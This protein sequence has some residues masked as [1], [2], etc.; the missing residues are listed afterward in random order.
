MQEW[1]LESEVNGLT[2]T[3]VVYTMLHKI[4]IYWETK[5]VR[6][7]SH[8]KLSQTAVDMRLCIKIQI[9]LVICDR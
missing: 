9:S 1:K 4:A 6:D 3:D 8:E 5:N 7:V 2:I